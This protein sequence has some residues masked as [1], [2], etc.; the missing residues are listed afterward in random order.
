MV[1][2]RKKAGSPPLPTLQEGTRPPHASASSTSGSCSKSL[3]N[4]SPLT[5]RKGAMAHL[6]QAC[7]RKPGIFTDGCQCPATLEQPSQRSLGQTGVSS[8]VPPMSAGANRSNSRKKAVGIR[9]AFSESTEHKSTDRPRGMK[10]LLD[11]PNCVG[12]G[13]TE[14]SVDFLGF[15]RIL[16]R[17]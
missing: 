7:E 14:L 17:N 9:R 11:W 4:S 8:H 15:G 13:A 16:P 10:A 1:T 5:S 12:G 6:V 2:K 3:R